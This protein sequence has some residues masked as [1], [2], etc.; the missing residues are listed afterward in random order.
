MLVKGT[1]SCQGLP[2]VFVMDHVVPFFCHLFAAMM[3]VKLKIY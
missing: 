3:L 1:K 2:H